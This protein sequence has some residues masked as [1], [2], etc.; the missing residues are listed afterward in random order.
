MVRHQMAFGDLALLL[1]SQRV[2]E[3]TQL[4]TGL[5]KERFPPAPSARIPRGI[6]SPILHE[7]SFDKF[8]TLHPLL[9]DFIKP[10]GEDSTPGTVKPRPVSLVQP[11]AYPLS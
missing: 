1:P 5:A 9:V 2:E 11:V 4:P 7:I 8:Q 10:L 3:R 6:C